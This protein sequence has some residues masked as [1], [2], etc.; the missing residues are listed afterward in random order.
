MARPNLITAQD[1]FECGLVSWWLASFFKAKLQLQIHTDFLNPYFIPEAFL[2]RLR[3]WLAGFLLPRADKIRVVSQRILS[4]L[5]FRGWRLK[6]DPVVLPV[7]VNVEG[8]RRMPIRTN[9][10]LKYPQFK[11]IILMASRL[12]PEK[13]I[14]LAIEAMLEIFKTL[15]EVGLLIVGSGP[16]E[17]ALKLKTR[18]L[19]LDANLI[20][21]SWTDDLVSYYKTA[22]LFLLASDYEGYGRTIVEALAA[23]CPVVSTDVGLAGESGYE[24][25]IIVGRDNLVSEIISFFCQPKPAI[26]LNLPYADRQEYLLEYHQTWLN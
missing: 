25:I 24:G 22:D 9:L 11:K 1:P 21:E 5:R 8:I 17:S 23:G 7:F 20:F 6:A 19:K 12:T 10:H 13:N 16:L 14:G 3:V 26:N 18:S 15:P 4:S 2:N